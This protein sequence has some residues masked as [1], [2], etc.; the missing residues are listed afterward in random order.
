MVRRTRL[1]AFF[2]PPDP[3]LASRGRLIEP[4]DVLAVSSSRSPTIHI[5]GAVNRTAASA[6]R[7]S[8][9]SPSAWPGHRRRQ[10]L[11]RG[12]AASRQPEPVRAGRAPPPLYWGSADGLLAG[13][14]RRQT[15]S[16]RVSCIRASWRCTRSLK[17]APLSPPSASPG[18][19]FTYGTFPAVRR[20]PAGRRSA[21]PPLRPP[22]A[23]RA[24]ALAA[25]ARLPRRAVRHERHPANRPRPTPEPSARRGATVLRWSADGCAAPPRSC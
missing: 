15:A 4:R 22:R 18:A 5:H 6:W 23:A 3:G 2:P 1:G 20:T 24:N 21:F 25:G 19:A 11:T 12:F 8:A 7:P 14:G 16:A 13:G 17:L 9:A 10:T